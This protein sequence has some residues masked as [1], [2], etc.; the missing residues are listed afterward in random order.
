[1]KPLIKQLLRENF[2][3]TERRKAYPQYIKLFIE[4]TKKEL[5]IKGKIVVKLTNSRKELTTT[6]LYDLKEY[7]NIIIYNKDRALV[8]LCRSTGHEMFHLKQNED[9][10]LN[11]PNE[12]GKDGS[13]IENEANAMAGILIRKFGKLHKEIYTL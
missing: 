3:V 2:D 6:A 13:D 10:R 4:F 5:N 9:G 1:M 12:Q 11:N 8:D 7:P